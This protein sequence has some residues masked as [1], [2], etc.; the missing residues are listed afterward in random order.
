MAY[1]GIILGNL[2]NKPHLIENRKKFIE[3]KQAK[4][5]VIQTN[6]PYKNKIDTLF[7]DQRNEI[8]KIRY[9]AVKNNFATLDSVNSS[10][11]SGSSDSN[12]NYLVICC[13]GNA[14]F[15]EVGVFQVVYYLNWALVNYRFY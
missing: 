10:L 9:N 8:N 5:A 12:G 13:D 7:V 3:Q 14:S 6:G 1:P 11:N 15:Y 2:I 4:R